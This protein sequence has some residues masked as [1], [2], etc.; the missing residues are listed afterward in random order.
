MPNYQAMPKIQWK[1]L[2]WSVR[3]HLLERRAKRQISTEELVLLK[4]WIE[5]DPEVPDGQW[6]KDFGSFKVCGE[7]NLPKTFLLRGQPAKGE[8]LD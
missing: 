5:S 8:R 6:Y 2:P 4:L 1:K 7:G 3:D